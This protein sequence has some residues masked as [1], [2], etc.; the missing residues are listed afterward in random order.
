MTVG[1]FVRLQLIGRVTY[2]LGWIALVCGGLV[3]FQI[4][5]AVFA[6]LSVN[7]RNLFELS[8]VCFLICMASELRALALG[9]DEERRETTSVARRQAAA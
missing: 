5:R 9:K 4:A 8:V 6:A 3:H 1:H 7:K 2:Y